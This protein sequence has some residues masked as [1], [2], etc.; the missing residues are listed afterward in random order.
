[1]KPA[2][3]VY[4]LF[5]T[6]VIRAQ[7]FQITQVDAS[8]FPNIAVKLKADKEVD[9]SSFTIKDNNKEINDF[10]L[11]NLDS[12]SRVKGIVCFLIEASGFISDYQLS[13]VKKAINK[14]LLGL[15]KNYRV[16][17]CYYLKS[18]SEGMLRKLSSEF[19]NDF[20]SLITDLNSKVYKIR[21]HS[22]VTDVYKVVYECLEYIGNKTNLPSDKSIILISTGNNNGTSAF[23]IHE[24]EEKANN[25]GIII[26][27]IGLRSATQNAVDNLKILSE[28]TNGIYHFAKDQDDLTLALQQIS[29]KYY[30]NDLPKDHEYQLLYKSNAKI[31]DDSVNIGVTYSGNEQKAMYD[32]SAGQSQKSFIQ[33]NRILLYVIGAAIILFSIFLIVFLK[34]RSK[35]KEN[36][37]RTQAEKRLEEER[38]RV[39][40]E[41]ITSEK[42]TASAEV[43]GSS[44]DTVV[45]GNLNSERA[46]ENLSR[47]KVA[48][49]K[50]P[51]LTVLQ[52][53]VRETYSLKELN[54]SLGRNSDNDIII[55][56]STV[57]GK[58]AI[59]SIE[60]NKIYIKDN[61]STNGTFVNDNKV[62]RSELFDKD[63][64]RLGKVAIQY[65]YA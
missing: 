21:D 6:T 22:P 10:Q 59:V 23:S 37:L 13:F 51:Q 2:L 40:Q 16:N 33:K 56:D 31:T 1:M 44:Q 11:V 45:S 63:T 42:T 14:F 18:N 49:I 30:S 32:V 61:N 36:A 62:T 35:A 43:H 46:K 58:H 27:S 38:L 25:T 20:Q 47:T 12:T 26:N 9:K 17:V 19:T 34:N 54:T 5:I 65:N 15:N 41:G 4:L 29:G 50:V 28:K 53:G 8:A 24:C 64:I 7:T 60:N 48:G 57:S 39:M 3:L 52:N 55:P